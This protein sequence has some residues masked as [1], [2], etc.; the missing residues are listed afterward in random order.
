MTKKQKIEW[1][2][3]TDASEGK[4]KPN[5]F[6]AIVEANREEIFSASPSLYKF[7]NGNVVFS[8]PTKSLRGLFLTAAMFMVNA[9][10]SWM[11]VPAKVKDHVAG[12][13]FMTEEEIRSF[14][15]D[16]LVPAIKRFEFESVEELGAIKCLILAFG[17]HYWEGARFL[18]EKDGPPEEPPTPIMETYT[19]IPALVAKMTSVFADRGGGP[20]EY[21]EACGWC[22]KVMGQTISNLID[23]A[24]NS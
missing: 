4:Q 14:I 22:R 18:D 20:K 6:S 17:F 15:S 8:C 13:A 1:L 7:V 21:T 12:D 2:I 3:S 23:E 10:I 19:I 9:M 11:N 24:I 5:I 16:N